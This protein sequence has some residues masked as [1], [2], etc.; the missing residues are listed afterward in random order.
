MG[1]HRKKKFISSQ[2]RESVHKG[3]FISTQLFFVYE[4]HLNEQV[5][6]DLVSYNFCPYEKEAGGY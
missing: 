2:K 6:I 5:V 3:K 4:N 1:V